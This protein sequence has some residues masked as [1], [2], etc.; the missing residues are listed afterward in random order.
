MSRNWPQTGFYDEGL[1]DHRNER[2]LAVAFANDSGR[3]DP[4][5]WLGVLVGSAPCA[6]A[7]LC[8][9]LCGGNLDHGQIEPQGSYKR[10]SRRLHPRGLSRNEQ[11]IEN[12][13]A[14]KGCRGGFFARSDANGAL[15]P[16]NSKRRQALRRAKCPS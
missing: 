10:P 14:V 8:G 12:R 11:A 15:A 1:I 9:R 6:S 3:L 16:A 7:Q 13:P 2:P 4:G 5:L